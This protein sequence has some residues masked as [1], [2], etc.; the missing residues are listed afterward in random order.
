MSSSTL[1][2][3][4]LGAGPYGL[5]AAARLRQV[6]GLELRVFGEPMNFW[7][8]HMPEGMLLRSP[9]AASNIGSDQKLT[10]DSFRSSTCNSIPVPIL[11]DQFV[12]YGLWVQRQ[13]VPDVDR[14]QI[15]RV[16]KDQGC[17]RLTLTDGEVYKSRRVVVAAG[18]GSFARRLPSSL[19]YRQNL[20]AMLP[21]SAISG[22]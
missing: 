1:D 19:E 20:Q 6:Q 7:K 3:L 15:A 11:L 22:D 12:E 4:I 18:I 5:G 21:I 14:R 2:V 16:D 8:S 17:F 13:A 9:W 10:L